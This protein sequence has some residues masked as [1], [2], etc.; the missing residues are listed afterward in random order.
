[1]AFNISV[2]I[3]GATPTVAAWL[4]EATGDLYMPAYYLM[5][6]AVVGLITG[7]KMIETANKP[8]RGATPAASDKSEAK[9][10]LSEHYDSIEHRVEDIEAEIEALQKKRQ[11]LIDQH[12]KLD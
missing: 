9:E 12:P 6:V 10:I 5:I 3:A 2:L 11:A 4:V 1:I 8:L 7:I